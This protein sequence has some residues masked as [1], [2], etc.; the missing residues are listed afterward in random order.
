MCRFSTGTVWT[1]VHI[2][3]HPIMCVSVSVCF[4]AGGH[5]TAGKRPG[6]GGRA[7]RWTGGSPAFPCTA[8]W[9]HGAAERGE[10]SRHWENTH[11][12]VLPCV[13]VCVCVCVLLY[14]EEDLL[15]PL[16]A[17][18]VPGRADVDAA[19]LTANQM[20]RQQ[21]DETLREGKTTFKGSKQTCI[22]ACV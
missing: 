13:C 9:S 6:C 14:H 21:H 15:Q 22:K 20:L 11:S 8:G 2:S 3:F 17:V 4:R 18:F 7:L 16:D 10:T 19:R 5:R 1:Q 12:V